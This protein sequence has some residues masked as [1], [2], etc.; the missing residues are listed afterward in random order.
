MESH[1][2]A[3]RSSVFQRINPNRRLG[4][5]VGWKEELGGRFVMRDKVSVTETGLWSEAR[6]V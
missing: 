6:A 1:G 3:E 4:I 2:E 5:F